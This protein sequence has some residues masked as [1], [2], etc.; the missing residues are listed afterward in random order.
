MDRQRILG[1]DSRSGFTLVELLV[2]I[3]IIGILVALLLPAVQ[4]AREAARRMSCVN[5]LKQIGLSLH[6]YHSALQEFPKGAVWEGSDVFASGFSLLLPY[7]E[8]PALES[9]YDKTDDWES[10]DPRVAATA[11]SVF[12]CPSTSEPNPLEYP[13][14]LTVVDFSVYGTTD[15]AF[16]KGAGDGWCLRSLGQGVMAYGDMPDL[17][18]GAFDLHWGTSIRKI[19]DGTS[20]TFALGEASCD[21]R[22]RVCKK[23]TGCTEPAMDV[24]GD[25]VTPWSGWILGEPVWTP[26]QSIIATSIYAST[27]EQMNKPMVSDSYMEIITLFNNDCRSSDNEGRGSV[28]NF[29][30]EHSGGC[31]FVYADGSVHFLNE[32]IDMFSYRA[33]STIRAADIPSER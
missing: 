25:F 7:L 27:F 15:Y 17:V 2:V 8:E 28:S 12:N 31:N 13:L 9:L 14:M 1:R 5:N 32:N 23:R 19:K 6:N 18:R 4:T 16:C 33:L 29:R 3:A 21:P 26:F 24:N 30:S 20:Q 11:I 10:Q 22:W